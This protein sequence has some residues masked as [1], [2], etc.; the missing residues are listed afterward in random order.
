MPTNEASGS[1]APTSPMTK[2]FRDLLLKRVHEIDAK[3]S[4]GMKKKPQMS[5]AERSPLGKKIDE[6]LIQYFAQ[7]PRYVFGRCPVC[8][9]LLEQ[10]FD[11][12]GLDGF[13]WQE[14]SS[15][16]CPKPSACEHFRVLTG[17]LN[18]NGN[19][20]LGG[21]AESH[22]GPEVPYVIPK[23]LELPTMAAVISSLRLMN[24]YAAYPIAYFSLEKPPTAALANPW[25]KTSCNFTA[26]NGKR[27]FTYLTDPW[28]F[29]LLPW[30]AKGSVKWIEPQ[31]P[32]NMLKSGPADQCPYVNL[33]GLRLQQLIKNGQRS[34]I[35]P[36][37]NEVINPFS[38]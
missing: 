26:P 38:D 34:T 37:N 3:I 14:D 27:G 28:D 1:G 2:E 25:T 16:H 32:Q 35:P 18:L 36:P 12:W 10:V 4:E 15:G 13:W 6:L 21:E 22:P 8:N 23:V 24:G 20:P 31:D 30:I 9:L 11:P 19:P 29:E 7:L 17:A 33:K 5:Y